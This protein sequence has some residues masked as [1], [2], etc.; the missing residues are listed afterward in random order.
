MIPPWLSI[1]APHGYT[2]IV[3]H[4]PKVVLI[5]HV[6]TLAAT[7]QIEY[8]HRL[9]VLIPLSILHI[10]ND[11][12]ENQ[13]EKSLIL[14][15][16]W[17]LC[18]DLATLYLS[19]I[20]TSKHYFRLINSKGGDKYKGGGGDKYA[21]V[22]LGALLSLL[23][24]NLGMYFDLTFDVDSYDRLWIAPVISHILLNEIPMIN[25]KNIR[26]NAPPF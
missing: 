13:I 21:M 14:H 6:A 10:K 1:V 25:K 18:H 9:L 15:A 8:E 23:M 22:A 17:F 16:S 19:L 4:N 2:D 26:D 7:T 12:E 11:F 24:Y 5:S 20:H 3:T